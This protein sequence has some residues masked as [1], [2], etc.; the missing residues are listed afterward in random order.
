MVADSISFSRLAVL[1]FLYVSCR[2]VHSALPSLRGFQAQSNITRTDTSTPLL[3]G[4]ANAGV[5]SNTNSSNAITDASDAIM[6]LFGGSAS[7]GIESNAISS[8]A[9]MDA[10]DAI[11][12]SFGESANAGVESNAISSDAIM[13]ASDAIMGLFGGSANAGTE[14]NTTSSDEIVDADNRSMSTA[15]N[16]QLKKN[17]DDV[18]VCAEFFFP[19]RHAFEAVSERAMWLKGLGGS[20]VFDAEVFQGGVMAVENAGFDS[21]SQELF[22][23]AFAS[24]ELAPR[25]YRYTFSVGSRASSCR[26]LRKSSVSVEDNKN[27]FVIE[28]PKHNG[29]QWTL[30]ATFDSSAANIKVESQRY[31]RSSDRCSMTVTA[32][33]DRRVSDVTLDSSK[34]GG[35]NLW[36]PGYL[37]RGGFCQ[38]KAWTINEDPGHRWDERDHYMPIEGHASNGDTFSMCKIPQRQ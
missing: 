36:C 12:D 26:A 23:V 11:M 25:R 21:Q 35:V 37:S 2:G 13:D 34:Y 28:L 6:D 8:G 32:E 3:G 29:H 15:T 5:E 20:I 38:A 10:S 9:I 18:R 16:R 33:T 31:S 7:A 30:S 17:N 19:N 4:S 27:W 24:T 14:S 22:H 1:V